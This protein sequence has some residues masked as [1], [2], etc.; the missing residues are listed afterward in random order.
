MMSEQIPEYIIRKRARDREYWAKNKERMI[1]VARRSARIRVAA[2]P[3]RYY[4]HSSIARAKK[5]NAL[6]DCC[7]IDQFI[8][9]YRAAASLKWQVDHIK[10]YCRGGIHC[11]S[12]LQIISPEKHKIKTRNDL[13]RKTHRLPRRNKPDPPKVDDASGLLYDDFD[14]ID[15]REIDDLRRSLNV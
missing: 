7:T 8:E 13:R 9:I 15:A 1:G 14:S 5:N 12:N 4:A 3:G 2:D 10:P 11:C 6:C